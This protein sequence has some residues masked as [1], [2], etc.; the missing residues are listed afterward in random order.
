MVTMIEVIEHL[1]PKEL[2]NFPSVVFQKIKPMTVVITT[3]NADFNVL[4]Q[5][6]G[7]FRHWDHKFEWNRKQFA[8]WCETICLAYHYRY[9]I[10][11]IGKGPEGT[12]KL[13]CCSQ[14]AVFT[15]ITRDSNLS[16]KDCNSNIRGT[17]YKLIKESIY[18]YETEC[19]IRKREVARV[20]MECVNDIKTIYVEK[21]SNGQLRH[22]E[23]NNVSISKRNSVTPGQFD[24]A[25]NDNSFL[26]EDMT[27]ISNGYF[28]FPIMSQRLSKPQKFFRYHQEA[29]LVQGQFD[30]VMDQFSVGYDNSQLIHKTYNDPSIGLVNCDIII[31]IQTL[32]QFKL[33]QEFKIT[34]DDVR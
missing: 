10:S 14:M 16:V 23:N 13:G 5:C 29:N 19:E 8:E 22:F 9:V 3:P 30:D 12:E 15:R 21:E 1:F 27:P 32:L 33:L 17:S 4:F 6:N 20:L 34:E 11:G 2:E 31:P 24:D 7:Q 28:H 18:P 26:A 25:D